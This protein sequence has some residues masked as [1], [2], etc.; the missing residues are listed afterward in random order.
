MSYTIKLSD[1]LFP[2]LH[3]A[4]L[5]TVSPYSLNKKQLNDVS[6]NQYLTDDHKLVRNSGKLSM[7]VHVLVGDKTYVHPEGTHVDLLNDMRS[8]YRIAIIE[9]RPLDEKRYKALVRKQ[10]RALV[11]TKQSGLLGK[12]PAGVETRFLEYV[13]MET[14]NTNPAQKERLA[15]TDIERALDDLYNKVAGRRTRKNRRR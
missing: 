13:G 2:E 10:A 5:P 1:R 12:F 6:E 15:G 11:D 8:G 7:P 4:Y 3:E 14:P 9:S